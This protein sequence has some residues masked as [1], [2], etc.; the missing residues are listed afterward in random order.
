MKFLNNIWKQGA[1]AA[2]V[3]TLAAMAASE[4][5]AG[6][7]FLTG[8]DTLFH[9][10]QNGFDG[11]ILDFLRGGVAKGDY[12]IAV[13]GTANVGSGRFTG[14]PTNIPGV[15]HGNSIPLAGAIAGYQSATFYDAAT[16]AADPVS[17]AAALSKS[18]LVILSHTSCGGCSL[19]DAGVNALN[20]IAG[21]IAVAF[22]AG[23]DIWGNSGANNANY[24]NFLPAGAVATGA[25][26]SGSTGFTA[27]P[28]GVAIGILPNMINGHPTHNRFPSYAPAFTEFELRF[29]GTPAEEVISIGL[30][31]GIIVDG[32]IIIDPG[33]PTGVPDAS[34]SALLLLIGLM[35]IEGLRRRVYR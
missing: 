30:T 3:V 28:E 1:I 27:T 29:A 4:A 35:G 33:D 24:Y 10:G 18:V 2:A 6:D 20:S 17:R 14:N 7:V 13:V 31:S 23:L 22:N 5:R 12:S 9:S 19:T 16:L 21:D 34:A 8:H 32:G 15:G 25:S 11:V 26:I